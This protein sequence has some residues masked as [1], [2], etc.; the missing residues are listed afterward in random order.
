MNTF[1][2]A[3][4]CGGVTSVQCSPPSAVVCDHAVVGAD[5]DAVDV[6]VRRADRVDHLR[7]DRA[8]LARAATRDA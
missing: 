6:L 3:V 7:A 5:P 4:S 2:N 1:M 8:A